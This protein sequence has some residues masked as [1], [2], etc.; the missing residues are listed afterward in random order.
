[1]QQTSSLFPHTVDLLTFLLSSWAYVR[2]GVKLTKTRPLLRRG[3]GGVGRS[4]GLYVRPL[5]GEEAL[6]A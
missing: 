5:G 4:G 2:I 6:N 1:M 3:G